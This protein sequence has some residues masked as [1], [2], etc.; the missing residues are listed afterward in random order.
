[1]TAISDASLAVRP[2]PLPGES[3][4]GYLQ[5]VAR[6]NGRD[7]MGQLMP[8]SRSSD[9]PPFDSV[10]AL[11]RLTDQEVQS[12][13]GVLPR[14]WRWSGA[15]YDLPAIEFN[16]TFKRWCPE[17]LVDRP[18]YQGIWE[19]KLNCVC[20]MHRTWLHDTCPRCERPIPW[21]TPLNVQC[22]C[23]AQ[24]K[25]AASKPAAAGLI[26]L[27]SAV[28]RFGSSTVLA[29]GL[30]ALEPAAICRLVKYMGGFASNRRPARPGKIAGL[31]RLPVASALL[32]RAD[33]LLTDWPQS[34]HAMLTEIQRGSSGSPTSLRATFAPIYRVIYKELRE[35]KYQFLRDEFE[36][37]LNEHWWGIVCKRN[38]LMKPETL[39]AHPRRT[40]GSAS[41]KTEIRPSTLQ[42]LIQ[43]E[44]LPADS[45]TTPTGKRICTLHDRQINE[46]RQL[47]SGALNLKSTAALLKIP[48]ARIRQMADIG[49]LKPI[50][51]TRE[52]SSAVWMFSQKEL[53]KLH[54]LPSKAAATKTLPF[55]RVVRY[56]H[57]TTEDLAALVKA[58]VSGALATVGASVTPVPIGDA[59]VDCD[60]ARRFLE[61]ARLQ[62]G[63]TMSVDQ[64]GRQLGIKQQ[65]AYHL[66]R[67]GLLGSISDSH[68][69][70]R[71]AAADVERFQAQ[72]V[73]LAAIA[74]SLNSSPRA[75]LHK[76][77]AVP[78]CG[79]S[80]DRCRQYF[81]KRVNV[82]WMKEL[83]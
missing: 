77:A 3:P 11:L 72:Y 20:P 68:V 40:I 66:V 81:Y 55:W 30:S 56:W 67:V 73:S 21:T 14:R 32:E 27:S 12:L 15:T 43:Q 10:A 42:L 1:M 76:I 48:G 6:A 82:F 26:A 47:V 70:V 54:V 29:P 22:I 35:P 38:R 61:S 25:S 63:G 2:R 24:L 8:L 71:I 45:A 34:F 13:F 39:A 57:V 5:R 62:R 41:I 51:S 83:P 78:V 53:L 44:L 37:H 59:M 64:A 49:L 69:G 60:E 16:F 18:C 17:C 23:G 58:I 46:I 33:L 65:V 36:R 4:A 74:A 75:T 80:I 31:Q 28:T 52:S 7:H 9:E 50:I 79:P 19:L